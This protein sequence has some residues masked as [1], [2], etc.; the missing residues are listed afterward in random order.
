[1]RLGSIQALGYMNVKMRINAF[2]PTIAL[3]L[4][5]GQLNA[6]DPVDCASGNTFDIRACAQR[7]LDRSDKNLNSTY[8]KLIENMQH[9]EKDWLRPKDTLV[10]PL[11][12]AQR[13]WI[14]FRDSN[15]D[16]VYEKIN[17]TMAAAAEMTC[18]KEMTDERNAELMKAFMGAP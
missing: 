3:L 11:K 6:D 9:A 5:S 14:S 2:I 4:L 17:G 12:K 10:G 7:D 1:M 8:Q 13:A 16:F 18:K 15:C